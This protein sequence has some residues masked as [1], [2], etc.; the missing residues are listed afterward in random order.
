MIRLRVLGG[1]LLCLAVGFLTL[2]AQGGKKETGGDDDYIHGKIQSVDAKA[3]SFTLRLKNGK[4]RKFMVMDSTKFI[5]PQGGVSK[6]GLMDD[7]MAK[8]YAVKVL[9]SKDRKSAKEVHLPLRKS[10]KA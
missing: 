3:S 8:G 1:A 6:K 5:G 4:D 9:P 2:D 10:K 7:R